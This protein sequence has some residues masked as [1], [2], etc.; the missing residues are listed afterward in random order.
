MRRI[1]SLWI[2][3]YKWILPT[4]WFAALG[5]GATSCVP[6]VIAGRFP[7]TGLLVPIGLTIFGYFV[8]RRLVFPLADEV[9]IDGRDLIV[10]RGGEEARFPIRE[11]MSVE[12]PRRVEPARV[13]LTLREPCLFGSEIAFLPTVRWFDLGRHPVVDELLRRS[14]ASK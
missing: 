2:W 1:S 12:S 9:W 4:S 3:W 13:E 8:L 10:R 5:F 7:I 6:A 14:R 11:I